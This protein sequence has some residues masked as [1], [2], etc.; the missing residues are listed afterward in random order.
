M[1]VTRASVAVS[2]IVSSRNEAHL[3]GSCLDAI[4]FCDEVIVIDVESTDD[5][6][7]VAEAHGARVVPHPYVPIAE[8]ARVTVAPQ[9]RHDWLLVVDPD[10]EVPPALAREVAALLP[11]LA[12]DVAAVD[13][14][15]QY[16]FAGRPLRGTVWGGPNKRRVLVRRSAVTLTPAIWGGMT[17]HEGRRVVELPFT[18][19]TAIVHR[20]AR[21]WRELAERHRRYLRLEPED[22]AAAGEVTGYRTVAAMPWRAFR[23]SYLTRRGYLDGLTGLRLSLFWAVFRTRGELA[24]LRRLRSTTL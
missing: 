9:A 2:A 8:A 7:A 21:G 1:A 12:D 4:S 5:T 24:L 6:A 10:E 22:R 11:T 17:I 19:E 14:P 16:Y 13:A 3:L 15:R 23:E 18:A 20:W